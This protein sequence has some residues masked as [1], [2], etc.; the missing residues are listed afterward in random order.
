MG[1]ESF[2][3]KGSTAFSEDTV[4]ERERWWPERTKEY[5]EAHRDEWSTKHAAG[6]R[7]ALRR[8]Q[9]GTDRTGGWRRTPGVWERVG[10]EPMPRIAAEV[11]V[12]HV[13]A[14]RDSPLWAPKTRSIYLQALRGFLRH[15]GNP[16]A[17]NRRLWAIDG[18]P[19][20]R[21][22][23]TKEQLTA[24]WD[25]CRDDYDRLAV[26]A[27]G[28]N[29]LRRVEVLR[30]RARDVSLPADNP[31]ARIWGKGPS[32]GKYRTIPVSSHLYGAL[33][34]LGRAGSEPYFPWKESAFDARLVALG[35]L[36]GL[37]FNPSGHTLRRTFGRLAYY[38]GVPLVSLQRIYG[39]ASPAMTA[40]YIGIDQVE[41]AAGLAQFERAMAAAP[42]A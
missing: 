14:V 1:G 6:V 42:E 15:C 37:P 11:T 40:H 17:E 30:L 41:M 36:A 3:R 26:A 19:L 21:R 24:I 31:E 32:G 12:S 25:V 38:A 16:I 39:H 4:P 2:N 28:F 8:Y 13:K 22:W 7:M 34:S 35:R 18:T 9:H 29:G 20:T 5:V 27:T 23:L 10:V 33:V